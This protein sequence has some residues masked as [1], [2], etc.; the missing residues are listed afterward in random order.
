M[1]LSGEPVIDHPPAYRGLSQSFLAALEGLVEEPQGQ[2]WRDVLAHPDLFIAVREESLNVYH[3]GASLFRVDFRHGAP[4]PVTHVKYLLRQ[5]QRLVELTGGDAFAIDPAQAIWTRYAGPRTLAEMIQAARSLVGPEKE[6]LHALLKASPNVI[7]VEVAIT[8]EERPEELEPE[9][10]GHNDETA[11]TEELEVGAS[12]GGTPKPQPIKPKPRLDRIDV[13]TLEDRGHPKKVWLVFHEVKTFANPELRADPKRRPEILNQM[14]RY[15][16]S[17]SGNSGKLAYVY[18][19]VCQA[20]VRL[21]ALKRK[22]RST[23]PAWAGKAQPELDPLIREVAEDQRGIVV[24]TKPRLVVFGFD[25]DQKGGAWAQERERLEAAGLRVYAVGSP[26]AK[27]AAAFRRPADVPLITAEE[28]KAEEEAKN[29]TFPEMLQALAEGA[30][31]EPCLWFGPEKG[32]VIPVYLCNPTAE[33]LTEV[34][35]S[36]G[37]PSSPELSPVKTSPAGSGTVLPGTGVLVDRYNSMWDGD[38][39]TGYEVAYAGADGITRRGQ[40]IIDKGGPTAAWVRLDPKER[41]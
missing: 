7:D 32:E 33:P 18:R 8:G 14:A 13:A 12:V 2:W 15:A 27:Q 37:S 39:L 3:R 28:L 41:R 30:P 11:G 21:D 24:E 5:Q 25:A 10:D 38:V 19:S 40:A 22:V 34:T 20:L 17:V 29:P 16:S 9:G 4:V 1:D 23:N 36:C 35:V 26:K 6:G 31:A